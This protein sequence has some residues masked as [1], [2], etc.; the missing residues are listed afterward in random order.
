MSKNLSEQTR[1]VDVASIVRHGEQLTLPEGMTLEGAIDLLQR[2]QEYE[3][4]DTVVSEKFDVLPYDG[5]NALN[6][7]LRQKYGWAQAI[8]TPGF[9]GDRPPTM[10]RVEVDAGAFKEVPWGRF[11]L[12]N[13]ARGGYIETST[14]QTN[15]RFNFALV[16]R[17]KR[18]DEADIR[19]L[20]KAVR[21][22][23]KTGSIYMG[24][25]IKIRFRNDEGDI[26]PVPDP[27]FIDTSLIDPKGLIYAHDVMEAVETNLFTP[28]TRVKDCIKNNIPVKRGILLGDRKSVV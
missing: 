2:R 25:A 16:A 23:L 3:E 9:F 19:S 1:V 22:F 21:T 27:S 17:I 28:I 12:P 8:P 18:K 13:L 4:E 15:G 6:E 20:F 24:K 5:A 14:Q 10:I 26:L 7:V 11:S